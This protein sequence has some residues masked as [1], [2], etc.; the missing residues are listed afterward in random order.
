M[1]FHFSI[2][3]AFNKL[4]QLASIY[5][6]LPCE[7]VCS[8]QGYSDE[9]E[10]CLSWFLHPSFCTLW[11]FAHQEAQ[12][13]VGFPKPFLLMP[14]SSEHFRNSVINDAWTL[15]IKLSSN[16]R[17]EESVW[18]KETIWEVIAV[19][20]GKGWWET[21]LMLSI[22]PWESFFLVLLPLSF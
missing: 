5:S 1:V 2:L 17:F 21:P 11:A 14:I 8:Q 18:S 15:K 20:Q 9:Q 13:Y 6:A 19:I 4:I 7:A 10:T 12:R 22:L 3:I 16:S